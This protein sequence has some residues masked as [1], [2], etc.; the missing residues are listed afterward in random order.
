[1]HQSSQVIEIRSR[2]ARRASADEEATS[3][4]PLSAAEA[5]VDLLVV[6]LVLLF[7][8]FAIVVSYGDFV[9]A[10]PT[11]MMPKPVDPWH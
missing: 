7:I 5:V 1:M 2:E 9:W 4:R 10:A 6:A 8:L 3:S 11:N